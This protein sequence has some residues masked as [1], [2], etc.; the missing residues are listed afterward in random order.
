[1]VG[2]GTGI[3]YVIGILDRDK[4]IFAKFVSSSIRKIFKP[5]N[6]LGLLIQYISYEPL[7]PA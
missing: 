7:L 1:M 3:T 6:S 4:V 5:Q 2:W